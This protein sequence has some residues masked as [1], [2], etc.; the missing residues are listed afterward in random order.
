MCSTCF[1]AS[2]KSL[3]VATMHSCRLSYK[4]NSRQLHTARP[5]I[6][7]HGVQMISLHT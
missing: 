7:V 3:Q 5:S 1:S 2:C 6:S 4:K